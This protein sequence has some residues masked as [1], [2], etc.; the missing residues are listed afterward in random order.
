[1]LEVQ[2]G[3]AATTELKFKVLGLEPLS[4]VALSLNESTTN[5]V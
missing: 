5:L 1:L 4:R 2:A 3:T